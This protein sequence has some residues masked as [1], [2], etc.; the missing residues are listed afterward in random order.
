MITAA[1]RSSPLRA[2]RTSIRAW[3]A[4]CGREVDMVGA[5]EAEALAGMSGQ[6]LRDCAQAR[7]WHLAQGR[8]GAQIA[9]LESLLKSK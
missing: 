5:E 9:C 1:F 4:E 3:C 2:A 6:A 8:D 7:G